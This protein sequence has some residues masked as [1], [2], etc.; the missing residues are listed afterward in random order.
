MNDEEVMAE[1]LVALNQLSLAMA[2]DQIIGDVESLLDGWGVFHK[3]GAIVEP[4]P[5]R[6]FS[7]FPLTQTYNYSD[8]AWWQ[9][10]HMPELNNPL[11]SS[12]EGHR[13]HFRA[14][15]NSLNASSISGR[16]WFFNPTQK[17]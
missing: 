5:K 7:H 11:F 1:G 10:L 4:R 17:K 9:M 14:H 12:C 8:W 3:I 13:K 15:M 6:I 2:A 16:E